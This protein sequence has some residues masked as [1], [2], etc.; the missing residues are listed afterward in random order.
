VGK[1]AALQRIGASADACARQLTGWAG[2]VDKLPF[3][4]RRHLPEQNRIVREAAPKARDFRLAFLKNLKP[5]HPLD[6]STEARTARGETL[7]Q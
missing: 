5:T 6:N 1:V 7:E 2:A 4:G 3:T